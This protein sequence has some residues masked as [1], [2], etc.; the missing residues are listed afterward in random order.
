MTDPRQPEPEQPFPPELDGSSQRGPLGLPADA[1]SDPHIDRGT[2]IGH[3]VKSMGRW[4]WSLIG[5]MLATAAIFWLLARLQVGI[6]PIMLSIIICT[7]LYPLKRALER[8]KVPGGLAAAIV[9]LLFVAIVGG[10]LASVA[11]GLVVQ[12]SLVVSQASRGLQQL[13]RWMAGPPLNIDNEQLQELITQVTAWLQGQAANIASGFVTGVSTLG[14]AVITFLLVLMLTFFFLKDGHR[15]LPAVRQIAGRRAGQ[16]L[17]EVLARIWNTLGAFIRT[18]AVVGAIDAVFI[19][20]GLM[21]L[22]VPLVMPLMIITF[23]FSFVP[24]VGAV[25]AGALAVLVALVSNGFT[26]ALWTL[27]IVLAVQQIESNV[28]FPV[29]QRRSVDVHPAISL[30]SVAI[31][32]TTFG[33]VGAFLAVPVVATTLVLL[34][35]LSEQI[36]VISGERDPNTIRVVTPDGALAA[37]ATAQLSR[38]FRTRLL[39]HKDED[40]APAPETPPVATPVADPPLTRFGAIVRMFRPRT[41]SGSPT[42]SLRTPASPPNPAKSPAARPPGAN[43]PPIKTPS[44]KTTPAAPPDSSA[45]AKDVERKPSE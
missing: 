37:A 34:R 40:Q 17:S 42:Q 21:I 25:V 20:L 31:G 6:I 43:T 16:H 12:I 1:A 2:V 45:P 39:H 44:A 33:L 4:G 11:P 24:T 30:V 7:V 36:D 41:A 22:Q 29:L 15:F 38:L 19:G 9:L 35:Y 18:Q 14:S 3:A 32:G 13:E 23:L 5:I 28:V 10:L 26:A 8:I 27:G